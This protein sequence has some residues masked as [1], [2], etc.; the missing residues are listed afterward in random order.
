MAAVSELIWTG[1]YGSTTIDDICK[2]A[3][4]K[5]GSFYYF[6][7]S[8]SS[9]AIAAMEQE[10]GRMKPTY[11][12]IFSATTHPL[13]R[14]RLFC[15]FE[16]N[17][18]KQLY[19]RYKYVLGCPLCTLGSEVSTREAEL[20][21]CVRRA[22]DQIMMYFETMIRDG[23]AAGLI[24][25]GDTTTKAQMLFAF[26]GGLLVQARIRNDVEILAT[27]YQRSLEVLGADSRHAIAA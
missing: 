23:Q 3:E 25:A 15:E 10:L 16:Y 26:Q 6:F 21:Q 14:L 1:S 7:D 20:L 18:Q 12:A 9:L 17:L 5:K 8:K 4:V 24:P 22:M 27:M 13:E 11:D 2:R 19:A